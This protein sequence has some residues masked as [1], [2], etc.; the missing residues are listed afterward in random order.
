MR[1]IVS[2][3]VI[4]IL[5]I[6]SSMIPNLLGMLYETVGLRGVAIILA[7]TIPLFVALLFSQKYVLDILG[8]KLDLIT[9]ILMKIAEHMGVEVGEKVHN[10]G[11]VYTSCRW[12]RISREEVRDG[13]HHIYVYCGHPP[14]SD[15]DTWMS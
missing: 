5:S 2:G 13:V 9:S 14:E 7:T 6:V 12:L 8:K 1:W 4:V 15:D 3:I 10:P 11:L